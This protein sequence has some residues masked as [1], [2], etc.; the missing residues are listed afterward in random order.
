MR[1]AALV[2]G[3]ALTGCSEKASYVRGRFVG[4]PQTPEWRVFVEGC[5]AFDGEKIAMNGSKRID[6]DGKFT[7]MLLRCEP[8]SHV[9]RFGK[10]STGMLRFQLQERET[11]LGD[12]TADK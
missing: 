12:I 6:P 1:W 7:L 8:G 5:N 2:A 11:D 9:L 10:D 3:L 4:Y